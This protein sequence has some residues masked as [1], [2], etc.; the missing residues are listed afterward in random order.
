MKPFLKSVAE[1]LTDNYPDKLHT[2]SVVF[3][4]K[5]ARIFF[6]RYLSELSSKP[7]FAPR[8]YTITEY[9]QQ[10]SGKPIADPLTLLFNLYEVYVSV[11][12]TKESFD[13]FLFY[14]EML[15][16]DFNDLDKYLVNAKLLFQN[17]AE[18][19]EIEAYYD[20]LDEAQ[21]KAIY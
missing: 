3:P 14:C 21:I 15:L 1:Y 18:I 20:Y 12:K 8:Y 17:L 2:I 7:V 11:T 9:M 6:N 16:A 4:N 5:R 19:K 10:I 13:D